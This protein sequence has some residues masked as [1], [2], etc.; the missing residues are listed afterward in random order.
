M[1]MEL[2]I[3]RRRPQCFRATPGHPRGLTGLMKLLLPC[4]AT[5]C[6]TA[7]ANSQNPDQP[8]HEPEPRRAAP[9][10]Q[11][12]RPGVLR[13]EARREEPRR[14]E[15]REEMRRRFEARMNGPRDPQGGPPP[16]LRRPPV[17]NPPGAMIHRSETRSVPPELQ[18]LRDQV[19]RLTYEVQRLREMVVASQG[20]RS[21]HRPSPAFQPPSRRGG[22]DAAS[23]GPRPP[24]PPRNAP[25]R[26]N[27][28]PG[29]EH[30][31]RGDGGGQPKGRP[32]PPGDAPQP[33]GD[34][35]PQGDHRPEGN[36]PPR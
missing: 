22:P 32:H 30:A 26:G 35:A 1:W 3:S 20:S 13:P 6:F 29:G 8:R 34:R 28:Q 15:L 10:A 18:E 5:L 19:R 24:M 14:T 36:P 9:E 27:P 21:E 17:E 2:W 4:V 16:P 23:H 7:I 31:P 11:N 12:P 33:Q 25:Q